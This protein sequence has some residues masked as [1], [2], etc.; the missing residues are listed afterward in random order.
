MVLEEGFDRGV[1][2]KKVSTHYYW[3]LFRI[4]RVGVGITAGGSW[5]QKD[6]LHVSLTTA[7]ERYPIGYPHLVLASCV[8]SQSILTNSSR[9]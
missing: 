3:C 1:G 4:K 6:F 9:I 2:G 5:E 8:G 7:K